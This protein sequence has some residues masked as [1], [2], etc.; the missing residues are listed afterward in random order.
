MAE[1]KSGRIDS[2][3]PTLVGFASGMLQAIVLASVV[4]APLFFNPRTERVFEPDKIAWL[5][6]LAIGAVWAAWA[7]VA[8]TFD[9]ERPR[10][11]SGPARA[12]IGST[13]LVGIV[14]TYSTALSIAPTVSL[15][16]SYRRGLGLYA[17]LALLVL[18]GATAYVS[19][20]ADVRERILR[21][22]CV[23]AV[24]VSLYA[25]LQ[26]FGI[27]TI[28]WSQYGDLADVRAFGS[29]GNALF[30]G[31]YLAM[32]VPIA[33]GAAL[34]AGRGG[35]GRRITY[36]FVAAI[37]VL[38][39]LASQSRGPVIGLAFG[40]A[41]M[42][43]L[44]AADAGR[45]R[46]AIGAVAG[47]LGGVVLL[48][49]LGRAGV[50]GLTRFG[51]LLSTSSRTVQERLL[52]WDALA[53]AAVDDPLR[54][55]FGHGPETLTFVLPPFADV[56]LARL[57]PTQIFDRA[58]D[59]LWEWW[60]AAGLIGMIAYLLTYIAAFHS[61]RVLLGWPEGGAAQGGAIDR[62]IHSGVAGGG[63]G[64]A[65]REMLVRSSASALGA[66]MV[67]GVLAAFV[68]P[69]LVGLAATFGAAFG[70]VGHVVVS[71]LV[72]TGRRSDGVSSAARVIGSERPWW[73]FGILAALSTHLVEGA[74]GV[75]TAV[76]ELVFWVLLG[77]LAGGVLGTAES[78]AAQDE[79]RPLGKRRSGA[80]A[81][82]RIQADQEGRSIAIGEGLIE[83]LGLATI[84]FAPIFLPFGIAAA[85]DG[86][87]TLLLGLP[88]IFW[89]CAD[90]LA[91]K[92]A[93]GYRALAR[94]AV[95]G[96][97]LVLMLVL[98]VYAAGPTAAYGIVLLGM[99]VVAGWY[100]S[101][102]ATVRREHGSSVGRGQP[103]RVLLAFAGLPLAIVLMWLV[104][105]RPVVA[106]AQLRA[107]LEAAARGDLDA[108]GQRFAR[109]VELWPQQ[110]SY[111]H[112][113]AALDR[114]RFV[115]EDAS[116]EVRSASFVRAKITL[117]E[118][119]GQHPSEALA[120]RLATL[121][122][123]RADR[124]VDAGKRRTDFDA[125]KQW[126]EEALRRDPNG[127]DAHAEFAALLERT[128]DLTGARTHYD[129]ALDINPDRIDWW[130]GLS[131]TALADGDVS[132]AAEVIDT[133]VTR[134]SPERIDQMLGALATEEQRL[135]RPP[136][137]P[138][139][140]LRVGALVAARTN[141]Y[142][143]ALTAID[144]IELRAPGDEQ[145]PF[146]LDDLEQA[147][148]RA[149]S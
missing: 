90:L 120:R 83:G 114:D 103:W 63:V 117:E 85:F 142:V 133:L 137:D 136:Y 95:L 82:A 96:V 127:P 26:R 144:E 45:R 62:E 105:L 148:G 97:S 31:A 71:R 118:A 145:V 38:G 50:P 42:V 19:R 17:T 56:E 131:R 67:A 102:A 59:V 126:L 77:V 107:G 138:L 149:D 18:F 91:P 51:S 94:L 41:T 100:F 16:G 40:L 43:L 122:R 64:T 93:A 1:R 9:G 78:A 113:T 11:P 47:G 57:T 6:C 65:S 116:E 32:V 58:H 39:I 60:V 5:I 30:L 72:N 109:A 21:M 121:Y 134:A 146:L 8:A 69:G 14:L 76:G 147:R 128:G 27:D 108:V 110:P 123:D 112:Y 143:E 49:G 23:V 12:L 124:A 101:G 22:I 140:S 37:S 36:F 24:P 52:A 61:G 141:R 15:W 75:P 66:A 73:V 92:K 79:G 81:N 53:R 106:D 44:V 48:L 89:V 4:S 34:G 25:I 46:L 74:L 33:L 129:S 125:S 104:A 99:S 55:V 98:R 135:D 87:N 86:W 88:V 111:S 2:R 139:W 132:G 70:L 80:K 20:R 28:P 35:S 13:L 54:A 84:T 130:L 119:Y 29:L 68:R 115:A 7:L 10:L 3:R